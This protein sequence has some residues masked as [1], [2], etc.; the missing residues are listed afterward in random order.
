MLSVPST[1]ALTY[2]PVT[3]L[4]GAATAQGTIGAVTLSDI[5]LPVKVLAIETGD[6]KTVTYNS[7]TGFLTWNSN[8]S[9]VLVL[10]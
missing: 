7:S 10:L 3:T 8:D 1:T 6:S 5:T 9:C 4:G 2:T